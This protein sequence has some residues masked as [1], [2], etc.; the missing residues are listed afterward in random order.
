MNDTRT[1]ER[2]GAAT[3][4]SGDGEGDGGETR[5]SALY[6]YGVLP[7][8]VEIDP[9]ATG[10]GEPPTPIG[11]LTHGGIAA[12]VGEISPGVRLGT[13][14]DFA[15]HARIL[16]EA[17]AEVPVLPLRFGAVMTDR[18]AV[19]EE[20]LAPYEQQFSETLRSLEGRRQLVVKGRYVEQALLREILDEMPKARQLQ[21]RIANADEAASREERIALG[22]LIGKSVE[23]RR[24]ADT[25]HLA[26]RLG[27]AGIEF[28]FREPTHEFDAV[29]LACLVERAD[30]ERLREECTRFARDQEG[31]IELRLLGPM[32]AYD[33]VDVGPPEG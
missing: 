1:R 19:I 23:A 18:D 21:Q 30:E 20:F 17:A 24:A 9:E 7:A 2:E 8:D 22:E 33:F 26:G 6:I 13:P 28:K 27:E 5:R 32:A 31:R 25:R 12:L 29:H 3:R 14:Q 11:L 4:G 16:D 15:A 10:V